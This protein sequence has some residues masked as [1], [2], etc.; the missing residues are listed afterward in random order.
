MDEQLS[1]LF[2]GAHPHDIIAQAGGTLALHA[3]RGD[4][5]TAAVLTHGG[6][7]HTFKY[8]D[9]IEQGAKGLSDDLLNEEGLQLQREITDAAA[10]LGINDTRFIH[11]VD[12]ILV[13]ERPL[14][15]LVEDVIRDVKPHI[16]ITHH[17]MAESGVGFVHATTGKIVMHAFK[18]ARALRPESA[19]PPHWASQ[20]FFITPPQITNS[21]DDAI[22][23]SAA[24]FVDVSQVIHLKVE[25]EK[26][27]SS[28][29]RGETSLKIHECQEGYWGGMQ[30]KT[31]PYCEVFTP[32]F[33][34]I[35]EHLP[36]SRYLR[37]RWTTAE[38]R[39]NSRKRMATMTVP[40]M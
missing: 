20:V 12:D 26:K 33:P 23:R 19:L 30:T 29:Y 25:A 24:V 4:R 35:S 9:E 7:A 34:E 14:I 22:P 17:P 21:L 3:K 8:M 40:Y 38:Q 28:Q 13:E 15:R 31:A 16:I 39:E 5:V 1:I 37:E 11:T 36:L 6:T 2:I 27:V 10:A 18:A 32:Y